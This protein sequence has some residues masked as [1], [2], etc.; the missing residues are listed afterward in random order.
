MKANVRCDVNKKIIPKKLIEYVQAHPD[1]CLKEIAEV[2]SCHSSLVLKL[3]R[4]LGI[5]RKKEYFLQKTSSQT[6]RRIFGN[7]QQHSFVK[8]RIY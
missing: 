1:T 7:Y 6:S 2:S 3:L 8:V 5:T 4:K